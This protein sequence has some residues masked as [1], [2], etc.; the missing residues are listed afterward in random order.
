[1][2]VTTFPTPAI[3]N[4][5]PSAASI[6]GSTAA[7]PTASSSRRASLIGASERRLEHRHADAERDDGRDRQRDDGDLLEIDERHAVDAD[8][9]EDER[10]EHG[11]ERESSARE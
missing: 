3:A 11:D 5:A 2:P 1:M 9:L 8:P 6:C 10:A 7:Q 4:S